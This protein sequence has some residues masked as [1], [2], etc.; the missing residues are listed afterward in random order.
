MTRLARRERTSPRGKTPVRAEM[1]RSPEEAAEPEILDDNVEQS[2]AFGG[3]GRFDQAHENVYTR[4]HS[5]KHFRR[6]LS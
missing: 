4:R 5:V 1:G 3:P 2:E 6:L